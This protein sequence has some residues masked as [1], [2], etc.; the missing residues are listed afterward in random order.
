MANIDFSAF[1]EYAKNFKSME[2]ELNSF[3]ENFLLLE[4]QRLISYVKPITPYDTGNLQASWQLGNIIN[5]GKH[6][7]VEILNNKEYASNVEYG[8]R[9]VNS[10]GEEI[11]FK[12][13]VFMLT[14]SIDR[15]QNEIP[16]RFNNAFEKWLKLK[17]V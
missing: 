16:Q 3:L 10:K 2:N 6:I 9:I 15:L 8:H 12:D 17:G 5:L 13:G 7:E 11:G 4:A 1:D 14:I